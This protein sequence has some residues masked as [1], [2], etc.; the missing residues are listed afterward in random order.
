MPL[1][2]RGTVAQVASHRCRGRRGH[3]GT[4]PRRPRQLLVQLPTS[5][6]AQTIVIVGFIVLWMALRTVSHTRLG[7]LALSIPSVG[8]LRRYA[9]GLANAGGNDEAAVREALPS[10]LVLLCFI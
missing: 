5:C 9:G 4:T 2:V 8:G 10:L 3:V 6:G 1:A 7:A